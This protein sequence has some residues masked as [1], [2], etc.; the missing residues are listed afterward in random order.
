MPPYC[1]TGLPYCAVQLLK[2]F[3][4][5]DFSN[6]KTHNCDD[7][8]LGKLALHSWGE[9]NFGRKVAQTQRGQK[10]QSNVKCQ[11]KFSPL[12]YRMIF[13]NSDNIQDLTEFSS[14]K[15]AT[16]DRQM[17]FGRYTYDQHFSIWR[18]VDYM[19]HFWYLQLSSILRN[20]KEQ[21][22]MSENGIT[23][24]LKLKIDYHYW[25][26]GGKLRLITIR[27]ALPFESVLHVAH[28]GVTRQ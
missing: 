21:I 12:S 9:E 17:C 7:F 16:F 23:L 11:R 6:V 18:K 24:F 4:V 27:Y 19:N 13:D 10:Y 20:R 26:T 8:Y 14:G 1:N 15:E 5:S 22:R 2:L 28:H 25:D 3:R